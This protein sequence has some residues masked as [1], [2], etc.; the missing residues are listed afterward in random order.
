MY[1]IVAEIFPVIVERMLVTQKHS[2]SALA[3]RIRL[4]FKGADLVWGDVLISYAYEADEDHYEILL[5]DKHNSKNT[6][7]RVLKEDFTTRNW[8]DYMVE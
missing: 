5:V 7:L 3:V 2:R 1:N 8:Q 4:P 6:F